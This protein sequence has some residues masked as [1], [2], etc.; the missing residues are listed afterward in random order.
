MTTATI[1]KRIFVKNTLLGLAIGES[2]EIKDIPYVKVKRSADYL[3][4]KGYRFSC[5]VAGRID[6]VIVT[7]L[8]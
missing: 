1:K 5:S 3:N 8:K 6:E 4:G 7:K 2:V